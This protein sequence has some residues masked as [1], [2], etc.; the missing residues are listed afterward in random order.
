MCRL[1]KAVDDETDKMIAVAEWTFSLDVAKQAE[2]EAVDPH[3]QPPANWPI[4]RNWELRRFFDSNLEK[5]TEK[6]LK[7]K[8][9]IS[10]LVMDVLFPISY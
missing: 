5:W 8:A 3:G 9:Y 10:A 4:D 2:K 7:G 6:Y 1:L